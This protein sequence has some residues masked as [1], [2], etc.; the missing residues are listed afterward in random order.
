[1]F[2]DSSIFLSCFCCTLSSSSACFLAM[3]GALQTA[4]QELLRQLQ[5]GQRAIEASMQRLRGGKDSKTVSWPGE[6]ENLPLGDSPLPKRTSSNA[7]SL[8][9][10]LL[11]ADG[12]LRR[13][14][15]KPSADTE[16]DD[17]R[18]IRSI[19]ARSG[20]QRRTVSV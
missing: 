9:A 11:E 4:N 18:G 3:S 16:E 5:L 2:Q 6:K 15:V 14:R 7:K 12:N 8:R 19:L 13:S 1:M 20:V 17:A 10:E